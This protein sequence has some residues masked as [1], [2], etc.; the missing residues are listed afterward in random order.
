VHRRCRRIAPEDHPARQAADPDS[1]Q[2]SEADELH[3]RYEHERDQA[4]NRPADPCRALV[5]HTHSQGG[6]LDD[7]RQTNRFGAQID[8]TTAS[9]RTQLGYVR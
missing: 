8:S 5:G 2:P 6:G 9:A 7:N 1:V 3:H 4:G